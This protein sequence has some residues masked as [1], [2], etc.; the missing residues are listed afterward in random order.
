MTTKVAL[1]HV[2]KCNSGTNRAVKFVLIC[3][4]RPRIMQFVTNMMLLECA[5]Y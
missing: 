3:A 4:S 5:A 2:L 1:A